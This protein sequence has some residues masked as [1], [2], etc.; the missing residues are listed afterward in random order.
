MGCFDSLIIPCLFCKTNIEEQTKSGPCMLESYK[1]DDPNLPTWMM[2]EFNGAEV[3]CYECERTFRIIYDYEV[4]VKERKLE[5]VD[6]LDYLELKLEEKE[7]KR[8]V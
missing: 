8:D 6:N 2:Q 4:I 5:T 1:W 3:Q 7:L